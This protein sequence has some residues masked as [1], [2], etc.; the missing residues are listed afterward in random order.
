MRMPIRKPD[1]YLRA[2][3]DPR[4]TKKKYEELEKNRERLTKIVRPRLAEEVKKLA[5]QGDFS[6]NAGYQISKGR[7][8]GINQRILEIED[9]LAR[10][11]IIEP[12]KNCDSVQLGSLVTVEYSGKQKT[13]QI[14]GSTE[15]D[16]ARGVISAISPLGSA[17]LGKK[18]GEQA[19]IKTNNKE[20]KYAIIKIG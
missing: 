8:R 20:I 9:L 10:A 4:L 5:S 2:K 11:E 7:L 18:I 13:Y 16:P 17:L 6:E 12:Q 19:K 15:T 3:A 1:K 14:L